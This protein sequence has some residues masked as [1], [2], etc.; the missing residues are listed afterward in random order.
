MC[1]V[2]VNE[3]PTTRSKKWPMMAATASYD[4]CLKPNGKED[5]AETSRVC[6]S[7][8]ECRKFYKNLLRLTDSTRGNSCC[9]CTV[10]TCPLRTLFMLLRTCAF[11]KKH[12][13]GH[14]S[15]R[16]DELQAFLQ[17]LLLKVQSFRKDLFTDGTLESCCVLKEIQTFFNASSETVSSLLKT[18]TLS[19]YQL[20][21]SGW[22]STRAHLY[23]SAQDCK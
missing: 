3:N 21:L 7:Y 1:S 23:L 11:Q 12:L 5:R 2:I 20:S 19:K 13:I 15:E 18:D 8:S 4:I 14:S 6:R 10:E 22:H 16:L 9:R 17:T